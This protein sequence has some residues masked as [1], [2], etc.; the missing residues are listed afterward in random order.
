[1][2]P[3]GAVRCTSSKRTIWRRRSSATAWRGSLTASPDNVDRRLCATVIESLRFD[4]PRH[5]RDEELGLFPLIEKRE[6]AG[7]N[8]IDILARLALEHATDESFADE[9]LESLELLRDG[10][11]LNNPEMVGYMLRSF[12]EC[13]RRHLLWENAIVLPLARAR[14]TSDDLKE[15]GRKMLDHSA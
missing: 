12:F 3:R 8:I 1:M 4:M 7:D 5:H 6:Q 14:L 13:Y 11:K 10:G 9:L 15:L 2:T